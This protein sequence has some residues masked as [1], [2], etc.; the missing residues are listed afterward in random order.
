[1]RFADQFAQQRVVAQ[2]SRPSLWESR[3]SA[4]LIEDCVEAHRIYFPFELLE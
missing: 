4:G 1:M 2:A 3:R